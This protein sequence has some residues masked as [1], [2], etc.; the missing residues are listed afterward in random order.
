MKK[1][2]IK[3]YKEMELSRIKELLTG[4]KNLYNIT[5]KSL[6]DAVEKINNHEGT[7]S[8]YEYLT[9]K[10]AEHS[11]RLFEVK[12]EMEAFKTIIEEKEAEENKTQESLNF[13]KEELSEIDRAV[14]QKLQEFIDNGCKIYVEKNE[15][16]ISIAEAKQ[17][18]NDLKI[19]LVNLIRSKIDTVKEI[20][21][22]NYNNNKGFD[23]VIV[24]IKNSKSKR[25]T[26]DTILAGGYN[27][28]KLHYRTLVK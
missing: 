19:E 18:H 21:N 10:I 7:I 13:M 12:D 4:A 3:V 22:L 16:K 11:K 2:D 15:V 28:Q 6:N 17:I 1:A 26:V 25:V 5:L 24:G 20:I 8:S 27:I 23:C 9:R 14:D